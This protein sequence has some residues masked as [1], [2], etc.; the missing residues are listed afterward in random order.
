MTLITLTGR[1]IGGNTLVQ[2]C[3]R[4]LHEIVEAGQVKRELATNQH[5]HCDLC[6]A[7]GP[8]RTEEFDGGQTK[9]N[10]H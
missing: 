2:L 1:K 8:I 10:L 6:V 3:A 5:G 4:H 7:E 9:T